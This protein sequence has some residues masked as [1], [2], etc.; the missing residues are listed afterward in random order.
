MG[1]IYFFIL[2]FVL[3]SNLLFASNKVYTVG[4]P[5]DW[6]PYYHIDKSGKPQ[7]F[8]IDV[9]KEVANYSGIKYKFKITKNWHET[10]KLLENGLIDIVPNVGILE[11][12]KNF[13]L[14]SSPVD[15]FSIKLFK[16]IKSQNIT[17]IRDLNHKKVAVLFGST[18]KRLLEKYPEIQQKEYLN[19]YDAIRALVA[20]DV[21]AFCYSEPLTSAAI[22]EMRL[23]DKI[24]SFGKPLRELKRAIAIHVKYP[25][26]LEKFNNG[27]EKLKQKKEFEEIHNKWFT[28]KKDL[29]FSFEEKEY[30]K[31]KKELS[32]CVQ[33][34]WLP[35][36]GFENG[37]F[38]GISADYLELISKKLGVSLKI[39]TAP[40]NIKTIQ[41]LKK[42]LCDIK[43]VAFAS[44]KEQGI[45]PY[46]PTQTYIEDSSS[47]ITNIKQPYFQELYPYMNEKFVM[48][49]YQSKLIDSVVRKYPEIKIVEVNDMEKALEMVEKKEVF[50]FIGKSL[51]SIYYIQ[52]YYQDTL[53]VV[54]EFEKSDLAFGVL[55]SDKI[56]YTLIQRALYSI[57]EIE[58]IKIRNN[59]AVTTIAV[60]QD[61]T[62][63][64]QTVIILFI[65]LLLILYIMSVK[66]KKQVELQNKFTTNILNSQ[67]NFTL[68]TSGEKLYR[69][70]QATLDFLGYKTLVEFHKHYSCI[71]DLFIKEEGYLQKEKEGVL[72]YEILLKNPAIDYFV[73]IKDVNENTHI[74]Q[75]NTTRGKIMNKYYVITL[76]DITELSNLKND[77][78]KRVYEEVDKNRQKDV[79]LLEQSK[80]ASM[81]EMIGNIAHQWRQPLSVISTSA[82]GAKIQKELE[83]LDDVTFHK[84]MDSIISQTE[85][86]SKTI[87]DFRNFAKQER[88][89][90]QYDI[91]ET[92]K[93]FLHL[94]EG[95]IKT[96]NIKVEMEIEEGI[97]L[98]GYP[99]ELIQCFINI[100]NNS[101]DALED[102][103]DERYFFIKIFQKDD[104]CYIIFKDNAGGVPADVLPHIFEPYF[105]TKHQAQGTGL[106]LSM[107]YSL[108][109]NGMKGGIYVEN[110][111]YSYEGK[112][113]LGAQTTIN[114]PI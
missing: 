53:K 103:T 61:N 106:G 15:T 45:L 35:Y 10:F 80:M 20:G 37:K 17:T 8:A 60:K 25:K 42:G 12:R 111:S 94:V 84:Y 33:P 89:E 64:W 68:I 56:L 54:N 39:I 29:F 66:Q 114:L 3:C 77:L 40:T 109:I 49:G 9:F 79:E 30:L 44:G 48:L 43:P 102:I 4:I 18:G 110:I 86:L 21:D 2:S 57:S 92:I 55:Q 22:R 105:T 1:K 7:G 41:L 72:W 95:S 28:Y 26:L 100:F 71:C 104:K 36:E 63:I 93:S 107:T 112:N 50:G 31:K 99:N 52:K 13:I 58:K 24:S 78:E 6:R 82:S 97:T 90:I 46:K 98:F 47:I 14:Y 69:T 81:G 113:L 51:S 38:I 73:K 11:K 101:K 5:E 108:I 74:F 88:E 75:V 85:Y 91:K 70:N 23:E 19:H 67:V 59:W 62:I 34:D 96:H 27:L 32:V 16:R 87:D 76:T 83:N 65:F